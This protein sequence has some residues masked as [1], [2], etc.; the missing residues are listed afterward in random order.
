M[1]KRSS[2]S[3]QPHMLL[4]FQVSHGIIKSLSLV[5]LKYL[6]VTAKVTWIDQL[7]DW[8]ADQFLLTLHAH[9]WHT[10]LTGYRDTHLF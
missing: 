9:I 4:Y 1:P 6:V 2:Q 10:I 5:S 7:I 8:V 3:T